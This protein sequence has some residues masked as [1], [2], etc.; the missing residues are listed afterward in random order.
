MISD[1]LAI[2]MRAQPMFF[3]GSAPRSDNGHVNMSPKGLASFA[4]LAP[5]RVAYLDLTGSGTET[6]A[7]VRENGRITIMFCAF[8]GAPS[9]C[10]IYGRGRVHMLGSKG[11]D[12]LS[13]NFAELPGAR[14]IIE[15]EVTRVSA[16][17]GFGVPLMEYR[18]QRDRLVEWAQARGPDG[19]AEY[20]RSKNAASIDGLVGFVEP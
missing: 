12:G 5:D 9:I 20:R 3:V 15:V 4:V 2:W 14:S 10:R 17:C 19:L 11:Y 13:V 7:H 1:D 8:D 6:I 18:G 16:S